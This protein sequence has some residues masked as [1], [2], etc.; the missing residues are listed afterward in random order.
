M[1]KITHQNSDDYTSHKLTQNQFNEF[2]I[3]LIL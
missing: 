1:L 2:L 3:K